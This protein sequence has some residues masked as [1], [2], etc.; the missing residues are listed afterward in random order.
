MM[1]P[2]ETHMCP[3]VGAAYRAHQRTIQ[4]KRDPHCHITR[5]M[6]QTYALE[7]LRNLISAKLEVPCSLGMIAYLTEA[8][9][10]ASIAQLAR[11]LHMTQYSVKKHEKDIRLTLIPWLRVLA[12]GL[13][14]RTNEHHTHD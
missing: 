12:R 1:Y 3:V 13:E 9:G 11:G 6:E 4:R 14:E 8:D 10:K 2:D 5:G 7:E